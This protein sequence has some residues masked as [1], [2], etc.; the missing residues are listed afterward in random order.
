MSVFTR[1]AIHGKTLSSSMNTN[2]SRPLNCANPQSQYSHQKRGEETKQDE[3]TL[4]SQEE[5]EAEILILSCSEESDFD[6]FLEEITEITEIDH[7]ETSDND[8]FDWELLVHNHLLTE[9]QLL[10]ESQD[11]SLTPQFSSTKMEDNEK[12]AE[13]IEEISDVLGDWI[14]WCCHIERRLEYI[15]GKT[16]FPLE[17]QAQYSIKAKAQ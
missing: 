14:D 10:N 1:N 4:L 15:I 16:K 5:T 11:L 6:I 12:Q 3:E 2:Q 8:V 17:S 7:Q 13:M 9:Q